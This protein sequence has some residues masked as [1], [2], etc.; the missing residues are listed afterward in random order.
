[1][2]HREDIPAHPSNPVP[3]HDMLCHVMPLVWTEQRL[4]TSGLDVYAHNIETVRRL[5]PY[6]RDKR[7]GYDQS[8][9]VLERAKAVGAG[10]G[11]YT[12][13]SI[14]LGLGETEDEVLEVK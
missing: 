13:S 5:Q 14:M 7:A 9:A 3:C 4:A 12:K 2:K 8:L 6:V 11:V 10:S 1:M